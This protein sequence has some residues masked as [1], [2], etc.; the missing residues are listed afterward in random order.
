MRTV[1]K[2]V[3][4][5]FKRIMGSWDFE[6]DLTTKE[7][8]KDAKAAARRIMD[9]EEVEKAIVDEIV[10]CLKWESSKARAISRILQNNDEA[11]PLIELIGDRRWMQLTAEGRARN[12]VHHDG[13][14][15]GDGEDNGNGDGVRSVV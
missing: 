8:G 10:A 5:Q 1:M 2:R 14:G 4:R 15:N 9:V 12:P 7:L 11:H 13:N 3:K 6:G